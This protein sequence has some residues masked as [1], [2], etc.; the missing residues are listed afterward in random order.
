MPQAEY[1]NDKY[2]DPRVSGSGDSGRV[3]GDP[4]V[5]PESAVY[6]E[7]PPRVLSEEQAQNAY[8]AWLAC[9]KNNKMSKAL[10]SMCT[11]DDFTFDT[12]MLMNEQDFITAFARTLHFLVSIWPRNGERKAWAKGLVIPYL[13]M[14]RNEN[15]L[16]IATGMKNPLENL[17]DTG[18]EETGKWESLRVLLTTVRERFP[19]LSMATLYQDSMLPP[20]FSKTFINPK[21]GAMLTTITKKL[22]KIEIQGR[23]RDREAGQEGAMLNKIA[24][25]LDNI[26]TQGRRRDREAGQEVDATSHLSLEDRARSPIDAT[27][28]FLNADEQHNDESRAAQLGYGAPIPTNP[29]ISAPRRFAEA[30][31]Q[32]A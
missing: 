17:K 14:F 30:S 28:L 4:T 3:N 32:V 24:K 16:E 2:V 13:K 9:I 11:R 31:P 27:T 25:K 12:K 26:E 5:S 19:K 8:N 23:H 18:F 6:A 10:Q 29:S 15:F 22:D 1:A 20:S 21:V 7:I